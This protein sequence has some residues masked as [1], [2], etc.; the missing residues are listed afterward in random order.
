MQKCVCDIY[1][2]TRS[3]ERFDLH[4]SLQ[5]LRLFSKD[6]STTSSLGVVSSGVEYVL[7]F[8]FFVVLTRRGLS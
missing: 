1:D 4:R 3:P 5:H 2:V 6:V 7:S 8:R